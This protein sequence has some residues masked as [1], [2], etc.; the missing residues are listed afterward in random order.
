MRKNDL[1]KIIAGEDKGKEGKVI[2]VLRQEH[3]L[4]VQ[5]I[6][7][8]WKHMKRSTQYP[9]GARIQKEASIDAAKA[10]L[11]CINCRKPTRVNYQIIAGD[12]KR[13]CKKCKQPISE[14]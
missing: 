1:V 11:V 13:V 5:G 14:Q 10:M 9:H 6:N 3:R 2:K 12:K 8:V 4:L 7:L